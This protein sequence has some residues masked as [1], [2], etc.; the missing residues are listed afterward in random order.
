MLILD[1]LIL[2]IRT[3]VVVCNTKLEFTYY[4]CI[5]YVDAIY[6]FGMKLVLAVHD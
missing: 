1:I 2:M 3:S 4:M 5:I 6:S